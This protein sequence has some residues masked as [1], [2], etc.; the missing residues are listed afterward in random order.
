M[1]KLECLKG[2]TL[3]KVEGEIGGD[4][5]KFE[6]LEGENYTLYHEPDYSE[7]VSILDIVGD[8]ADLIDTPLL[9]AEKITNKQNTDPPGVVIPDRRY[10]T[11]SFTW[12]FYK[13]STIKGSVTIRWHG[14]SNGYYCEEVDFRQEQGR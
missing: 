11:A 7:K 13:L 12:T 1:V 3:T 8:L 4:E 14:E 9:M 2:K 10:D 5:M 6:T